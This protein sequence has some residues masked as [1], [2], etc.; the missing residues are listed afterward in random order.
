MNREALA[1]YGGQ[2]VIDKEFERYQSIGEEETKA[3]ENVMRSKVLSKYIGGWGEDFNGGKKVREFEEA[4]AKYFNVKHAI[5]VNSWTSGLI[6]IIGAIGVEPGDEIIVSPWTMCATATAILHWNAIPVFA[7]I[8]EKTFNLNPNEVRKKITERTKAI[9]AVDIFGQ[10]CDI[11]ELRELA[12]M[13]NLI[14]ITDSAQ[15]PGVWAGNKLAGTQSDIGGYSLNYHKHI[16]TGEGGVIITN[17]DDYNIRVRLIRNHAEASIVE[18]GL[19]DL[20]NMIGYNFR[21]GEIECAIG[22]EQL[23]KL[24]GFIE[25]R[26]AAA[27]KLTSGLKDLKGL[28]L[29]HIKQGNTHAYYIY[30]MTLKPEILGVKRETITRAIKAEG[31][32]GITNGYVNV[33]MLPIF[34]EK[35][36]YGSKGYPWKGTMNTNEVDYSKGICPVAERLHDETFV[37]F[38]M[39]LHQLNNGEIDK[40]IQV[41][42]KV[43]NNIEYLKERDND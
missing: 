36:A 8:E 15:S 38:E 4:W 29:P 6:A 23:K 22:I 11:G 19:T 13:Y 9:L 10:S 12:K 40:V 31:L 25:S 21:L 16:H 39:C 42:K 14:L 5:T 20:K 32:D 37:G 2:K 43:W 35:I 34:Q 30:P 18:S 27:N 3:V 1:L 28:V 26:Q 24:E 33:H 41:F 7:D 17:N